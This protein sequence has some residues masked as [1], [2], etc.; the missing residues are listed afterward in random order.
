MPVHREDY[1]AGYSGATVRRMDGN[2]GGAPELIGALAV[3]GE[4]FDV[5]LAV[6]ISGL[7]PADLLQALD[8]AQGEGLLA[9]E[10]GLVRFAPGARDRA[11]DALG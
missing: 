2:G 4:Q 7:A 8:K 10:R 1:P 11:Y 5:Q 9:V 6:E 3:L